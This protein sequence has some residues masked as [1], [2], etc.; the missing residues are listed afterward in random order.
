[1]TDQIMEVYSLDKYEEYEY[2]C[3]KIQTENSLLLFEFRGWL[4]AK[5]LSDKTIETHV[6]NINFFINT[7]LLHREALRAK[8]GVWEIS[9]YQVYWFIRKALWSSVAN[10]KS[11]AASFKKFYK[12]MHEKGEIDDEALEEVNWMVKEEMAEWIEEMEN[13]ENLAYSDD[14]FGL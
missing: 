8:E 2:E 14:L 4:K 3:R 10:I 6:S 1:M 13:F 7:Y 5:G 12:F 11:N 9:F